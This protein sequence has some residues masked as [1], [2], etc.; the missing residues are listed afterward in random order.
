MGARPG[1]AGARGG[2]VGGRRGGLL[3]RVGFSMVRL[4]GF[5]PRKPTPYKLESFVGGSVG[6]RQRGRLGFA[7]LW[8]HGVKI[9]PVSRR[10]RGSLRFAGMWLHGVR[11][12]H[13]LRRRLSFAGL[14]F[15]G[16][17]SLVL[18]DPSPPPTQHRLQLDPSCRLLLHLFGARLSL[19]RSKL[20]DL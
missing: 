9:P 18:R 16:F 15:C 20:R 2:W 11:T 6:H 12:P 10:L 5:K 13:Q 1:V 4:V 19:L 17:A 8:P 3:P 7:R 14:L